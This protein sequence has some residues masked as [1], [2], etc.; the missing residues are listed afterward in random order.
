MEAAMKYWHQPLPPLTKKVAVEPC[1]LE[2]R[3][4]TLNQRLMDKY[5]ERLNQVTIQELDRIGG[6]NREEQEERLG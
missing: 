3:E 2:E 6:L 5:Y 4:Y 1:A